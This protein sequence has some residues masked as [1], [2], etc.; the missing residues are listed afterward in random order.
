MANRNKNFNEML[1]KEMEDFEFA[2]GFLLVQIEEHGET[3]QDALIVAIEA[4]GLSSFAK[5]NNFSIQSVSDFV[6]KKRECKIATIDKF[7]EPFGLR[8]K[9]DIEKVA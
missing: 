1:A 6:H 9:L 2:Q 7:L 8:V 3:I 5:N 4:V